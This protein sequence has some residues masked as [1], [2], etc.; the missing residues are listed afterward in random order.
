MSGFDV[1]SF[2]LRFLVASVGSLLAGLSVW[3]LGALLRR[4][5]P[6][7]AAQ[8]TPWLLAQATVLATFLLVLL[9]H[10][11]R[12]RL[13]PPIE[14]ATQTVAHLMAPV[15]SAPTAPTS[16]V[17]VAGPEDDAARPALL[18]AARAWF[19]IYLLG[20]A[21]SAA[22]LWRAQRLLDRLAGSGTVL[23][24]AAG[25]AVLEV[26]GPISPMLLGLFRPR[27]LLPRHLRD[28]DPLQRQLIVAHELTHLRRHDLRWMAAG[29]LLQT[30]LWF[31]PFLY[32]LLTSL[33][34]AQELGCDRDVL[35]GRP[36]AE[37]KA[38]AAAL[39]AQL[40][41]QHTPMKTALAFGGIDADT[42][43]GRI[44]LIRTPGSKRRAL[45]AR[46]AAAAGLAGIAGANFALQPALAWQAEPVPAGLLRCTLLLDAATG[47]PLQR[48]GDCGVRITPVS[49]F[50]I[51][52]SLMGYDSGFLHDEHAPRLPFKAGYADWVP[53]WR[54][55]MDPHEWIKYSAAWY[56]QQVTRQLGEERF[57]RYVRGFGYGNGD[58]SGDA[59]RANGLTMSWITSSLAISADEQAAFL[60]RLVRR[61]L[62]VSAHAHDMTARLLRLDDLPDGWQVYGKTGT[63]SPVGPDGRDD[64]DHAYGWFVGW[65]T[66]GERTIV[67]AQLTQDRH[68]TEG[69]AG[70]RTR[71]A[72]LHMLPDRLKTL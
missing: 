17:P 2:L 61:E 43:A 27:L 53:A 68:R 14:E 23:L 10:S 37:R 45:W 56:A 63:G 20:L 3:G 66:K 13:V 30:L 52:I 38:Y 72:F 60:R 9:P 4:R 46:C 7:L 28:F 8:R 44:A 40:K 70:P 51:A 18:L 11:E 71:A 26:D 35:R 21:W 50:N 58:T 67:F 32:R 42:L 47:Q 25:A 55:P 15:P 29:L 64:E 36:S 62:P 24:P 39:V 69:A 33:N 54:R 57:A 48:D 5:L 31:N 41:L 1:D 49:T 6:A 16:A 19:G 22:R 34:W 59:G 65:A 12:L